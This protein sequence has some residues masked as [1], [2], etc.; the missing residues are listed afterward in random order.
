MKLCGNCKRLSKTPERLHEG[1][2]WVVLDK[3][4]V[5]LMF[6]L[7]EIIGSDGAK[8]SLLPDLL[9]S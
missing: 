8:S 2:S 7:T 5:E 6:G 1:D 4:D 9:Q 3:T